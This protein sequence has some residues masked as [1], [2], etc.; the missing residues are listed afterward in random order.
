M[1]K[2]S[3]SVLNNKEVE[4]VTRVILNSGYLG[5]GE[6]VA[7]FESEIAN[8]IN[9]NKDNVVCVNSGTA[10]LHLAV[11]SILSKGDEIIVPSFT[12]L[13]SIQAISAAGVK[14]IFC[15][16]N[17]NSLCMDFVDAEKK[18]T[19]NTK[20][21]MYVHYG[22]NTYDID[23]LYAFAK[24]YNL[25]IIEDAAHSF[26][27]RYKNKKIGSFG[28]ITCFSFDGIKNITSGEG[29]AIVTKDI[30]TLAI[31]KDSRLLG[32]IKD[33]EKRYAGERSW[34]FDVI[35]QGYR[36]HMSNIFAAIGRVQLSKLDTEFAPKRIEFSNFY[37]KSLANIKDI[38]LQILDNDSYI[39]PHIFPIK[40]LNNQRDKLK[41]FLEKN[42]IPT[43]IH[44]KPNHLLSFYLNKD[45]RLP[46]T[47]KVYSEILTLP[48]HP[49][50]TIDEIDQIVTHIKSF[51]K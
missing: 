23:S 15:D 45:V 43:G 36:Y 8:Y 44:Y 4:A 19:T 32:I 28:D 47:E 20:A 46:I 29:G 34:D 2:L 31:V 1:I 18:I 12:F 3:K 41:E 42:N 49:N 48:L 50:L 26:G 33:S 5:M 25:R 21:I 30:K 16:I 35:K 17:K 27:C 39:I 38:E 13:S 37:R 24:K 10:A 6:E 9:V 14:P 51:Y 40:V 22:S 11:E 7:L